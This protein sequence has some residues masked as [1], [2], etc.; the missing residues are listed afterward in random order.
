MSSLSGLRIADRS[1]WSSVAT[2]TVISML[3]VYGLRRESDALES[4]EAACT[5]RDFVGRSIY[6]KWSRDSAKGY[7]PHGFVI[8]AGASEPDPQVLVIETSGLNP[9]RIRLYFS[10]E[11]SCARIYL[12]NGKCTSGMV[13]ALLK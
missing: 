7:L 9:P 1:V 10:D 6:F 13:S 5:L 11:N 12:P 8:T 2:V 3:L 4:Q